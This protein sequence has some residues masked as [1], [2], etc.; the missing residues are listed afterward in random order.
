MCTVSVVPYA[1]GVRLLCN[2]DEG[3]SRQDALPP[4]VHEMGGMHAMFPI[5]PDGSGTWIGC[6]G[7]GLAVTLL[8]AHPVARNGALRVLRSRGTIVRELL[9]GA[10]LADAIRGAERLDPRAYGP[11]QL[12]ILH[13]R[14]LAVVASDSATLTLRSSR[15]ID[16]PLLFTSSSLGDRLVTTPRRR[17][18][19]RLVLRA[20]EGWLA[21]QERFHDHQWAEHPELSVRMERA[22]ALTVSRTA[23]VV[24]RHG[25][26]MQYEAPLHSKQTGE[27][28]CSLPR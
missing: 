9:R 23:L 2:R 17:L 1:S 5:D 14:R 10:S 22:D 26:S 20:R 4:R 24:T 8:N 15:V 13:G 21:G 25:C 12:L 7:A 11:F 6:N 3:R 19:G 18:F 28:R 27:Q 16:I